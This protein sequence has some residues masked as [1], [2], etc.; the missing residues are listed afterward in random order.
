[1]AGLTRFLKEKTPNGFTIIELLLVITIVGVILAVII[2]RAWRTGIEAKYSL[3]RQ[4][5]TELGTWGVT[6]AERNLDSQGTADTCVLN[7]YV[8][9]LAGY[10]GTGNWAGTGAIST[11]ACH[12]SAT[13]T[14]KVID[15][16]PPE[17][18][19]RNPF[20][21]LSYFHATNSGTSNQA[22]LL[23]LGYATEGTSP[24]LIYNY[25]FVYTG[26]ESATASDWHAGMGGGLNPVAIANLRNGV[27]MASLH[28]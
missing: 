23:Y 25:Y 9:S 14:F 18:Q 17:N 6:W 4:S 8:F 3:V 26:T 5:A 12:G 15:I 20:N 16:M 11:P 19:P 27:F 13:L 2:P 10:T 1:M 22:G 28:E 7:D 21:G 24:N